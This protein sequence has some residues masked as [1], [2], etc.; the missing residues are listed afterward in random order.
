M[1]KPTIE[2]NRLIG[3]R[4]LIARRRRDMTQAELG[5]LTG[6]SPTTLHRLE[7]GGQKMSAERLYAIAQALEV[8]MGYF[9]GEVTL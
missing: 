6:T 4:V 2:V 8:P 7:S 3:E 9:F 5:R 1:E